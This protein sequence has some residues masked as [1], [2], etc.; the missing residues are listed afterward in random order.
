MAAN[1]VQ[2][3]RVTYNDIHNLIR[4][5]TPKIAA[6]FNPDLMVAIGR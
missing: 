4:A 3:W 6:E 5:K 2:H 1:E